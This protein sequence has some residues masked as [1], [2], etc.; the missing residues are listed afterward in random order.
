M[1]DGCVPMDN[2]QGVYAHIVQ[3]FRQIGWFRTPEDFKAKELQ[4]LQVQVDT[5]ILFDKKLGMRPY[6]IRFHQLAAE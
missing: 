1:L 6:V 3:F 5:G 2:T 4:G